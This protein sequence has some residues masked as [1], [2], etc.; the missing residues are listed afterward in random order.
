MSADGTPKD[1]G[2]VAVAE[3]DA[4]EYPYV[5]YMLADFDS[6]AFSRQL[7]QHHVS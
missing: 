2:D 5:E 3:N 7:N 6:D 1:V 4:A